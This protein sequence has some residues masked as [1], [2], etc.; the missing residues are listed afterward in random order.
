MNKIRCR[1]ALAT[2]ALSGL[3]LIPAQAQTVFSGAGSADSTAQ[4]DAFR[5]VIGGVDNGAGGGPMSG[6]RRE[7][8]W[9]GVKLDGTDFGGNTQ[10]IVPGKNVGIPVNR[11]G[12]RGATF[13]EVY[14]VSGDG[15][16]SVNP[17]AAGQFPAFSP[18]NTFAMFDDNTIGMSF[19]LAGTTTGAGTRGFG[20][21]FLDTELANTSSIEYFHNGASLGKYFV[22]VGGSGQPEFLGVLFDTPLITS[23]ELTLGNASLFSLDAG[24]HPVA[25]GTDDPFGASATD[26]VVTDD[27][28]YAEPQAAPVPEASVTVGFLLGGLSLAALAL[29]RSRRLL[30]PV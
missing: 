24:G 8:N 4:S 30:P 6:G 9:D 28:L 29:R 12:A 1:I 22:P 25:G 2:V 23:V 17:S 15:F 3:G 27:F 21:I 11:F 20:A 19:N 26:L 7:I 10:V 14:S 16:E 13:E 5:A 18:K